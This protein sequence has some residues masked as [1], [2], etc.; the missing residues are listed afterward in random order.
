MPEK[1][2]SAIYSEIERGPFWARP[3]RSYLQTIIG[4][5]GYRN[6]GSSTEKKNRPYL[7]CQVTFITADLQNVLCV[8]TIL[9]TYPCSGQG[10]ILLLLFC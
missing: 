2:P 8:S 5:D 6:F 7:A 3:W 9:G 10:L 4:F 1:K